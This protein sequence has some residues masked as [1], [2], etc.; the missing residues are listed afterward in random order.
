MDAGQVNPGHV[1]VA[2]KVPAETILDLDEY[3]AAALFRNVTKVTK[4]VQAAFE[5]EGLTLLQA[6]KAAGLQTV[7]HF[8]VHILPRHTDDGVGLIWPKK[9]PDL[10]TL[11]G[12]AS[13]ISVE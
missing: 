9:D 1:L 8:Q 4:A 10:E 6:N 3:L 12:H 11:Q 13:K 5:P 7:P 2:T